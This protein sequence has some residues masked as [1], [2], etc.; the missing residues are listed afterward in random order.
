MI[1]ALIFD[2][3]GVIIDS[4]PIHARV[5]T[6]V[7]KD[8]GRDTRP[9]DFVEF[10]GMRDEEMWTILK[11]RYSLS[12]TVGELIAKHDEY[13][14]KRFSQDDL[15]PV[16]GIPELIKNAK[17]K[18]LKISLA[19]SS[20]R[21]LAEQILKG[22]KLI[23]FFDAL[24]TGNDVSHSKPDPEVFLK[25]AQA[26]KLEPNECIV[27]E[28]SFLGIQAAKSAGMKCIA[29]KNPHSGC[30]DTSFADFEVSSIKD[31]DLDHMLK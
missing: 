5:L 2:M 26:L 4:E 6:K 13:K 16:E 8:L 12:G 27:I 24:V 1:K 7:L 21:Y 11:K 17:S 30:Q 20:P 9:D 18:N 15:E 14:K 25:A 31:I 22:L 29:Y 19:T 23:P 3:D 28:D 10:I